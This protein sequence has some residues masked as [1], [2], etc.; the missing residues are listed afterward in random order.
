MG[1]YI[2]I[3]NLTCGRRFTTGCAWIEKTQ[4][5]FEK[6]SKSLNLFLNVMDPSSTFP[7]HKDLSHPEQRFWIVGYFLFITTKCDV[8]MPLNKWLFLKF[9]KPTHRKEATMQLDWSSQF[10]LFPH[11]KLPPMR[12]ER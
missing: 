6:S 9:Q 3:A 4:H 7:L 10:C 2:T 5:N 12:S 1:I 8:I 11:L